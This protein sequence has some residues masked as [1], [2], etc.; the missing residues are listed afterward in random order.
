MLNTPMILPKETAQALV[1][2]TGEVRIETAL[3]TVIREYARQKLDELNTG[4]AG[5]EKKYGMS[6]EEYRLVWENEDR[7]E[8]YSFEAED[9]Y[10]MWEG[11]VTRR[12][13]LLNSFAWLP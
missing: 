5:F 7:P 11:F 3:T 12:K 4:L 8:D 10:L 13:R 9:D 6:F 1:D 2:L